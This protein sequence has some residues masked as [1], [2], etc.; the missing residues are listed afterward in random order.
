MDRSF[1]EVIEKAKSMDIVNEGS[2]IIFK[3]YLLRCESQIQKN[4]DLINRLAGKNDQLRFTA[5]F[6]SEV[7]RK[8]IR[9]QEDADMSARRLEELTE[10][11]LEE[12]PKEE[13]KAEI[14]AKA[15]KAKVSQKKA[16][17]KV[18]ENLDDK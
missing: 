15:P 12:A 13:V 6:L 3:D 17:K 1:I 5:S 4:N 14:P 2:V 18:T 9:L 8:Y 7:V 11:P 10:K 16:T